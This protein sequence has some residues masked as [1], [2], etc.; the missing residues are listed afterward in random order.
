MIRQRPLIVIA[1]VFLLGLQVQSNATGQD[2]IVV[3]VRQSTRT[4]AIPLQRSV[5]HTQTPSL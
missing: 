2:R 3:Q 1:I 5:M 4:R